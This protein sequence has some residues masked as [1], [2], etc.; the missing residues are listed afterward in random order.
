MNSLH[1]YHFKIDNAIRPFAKICEHLAT[2]FYSCKEN[3][4]KKAL[5]D[6]QIDAIVTCA[7]D[8]FI[9]PQKIATWVY[10][11]YTL[12]LFGL[13]KDWIH[14]ELKLLIETKIIHES[15]GT[16]ARGKQV[17]ILIEKHKESTL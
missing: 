11:I 13:Q 16:N 4:F 6:S 5:K 15:E 8:W 7:F 14:P 1:I 3:E 10:T 12:Y 2:A 9:T 17:L